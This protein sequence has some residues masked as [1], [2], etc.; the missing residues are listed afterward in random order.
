MNRLFAIARNAFFE[1]IRQP[2]YG[3]LIF[4]TFLVLVLDVPLS[5]WTMGAG[6]AEYKKTDQQ[7]L[8]NLGLSTLLVSGLLVS[9]FSAAGVL[10][11]EIEDRT[12]LTVVSKP[13]PRAVLVL[14]KYVGV[15]AALA[16]AYYLCSL[17]F[18]MTVRHGVM[19]T[20]SDKL[21]LPVIV[22]GSSALVAAILAGLFCNYFFSWNFASASVAAGAILLGAAMAVIAVV[23]KGWQIVSFGQDIS[24]ELLKAMLVGLFCVLVFAAVAIAAST[25]LGWF[26][27]L[28]VC[29][30]FFLAGS[31][32]QFLFQ[33]WAAQ[34]PLARAAYRVWPNFSFFYT[35][36]ALMQERPIPLTYVGLTGG[37]ALC[38]ILAILALGM[39]LF[40][41]R[42]LESV[43]GGAPLGVS[44]LAGL[45]RA[46]GLVC[47]FAGLVVFSGFQGL[48][49]VAYGLGL[50]GLGVVWWYFWG[51]FG[52]G[53]KWTYYLALVVTAAAVLGG[54]AAVVRSL[55]RPDARPPLSL[56]GIA[57]T[58]GAA[59]LLI[60]LLPV[61]R[62]HFSILPRSQRVHGATAS[63]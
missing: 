62:H 4:L 37:Y 56:A 55:L 22:L 5:G 17:A 46:A 31:M 50:V 48:A 61:T 11:R 12:V 51:W 15:A 21:D 42:E 34:S 45:G 30:G 3:V 16:V 38:Q 52:R 20:V 57:L 29:F 41:R 19:P 14:G 53:L 18:L 27:T 10:S 44:I 2:I 9:A 60:L 24:L 49:S 13:V 63:R 23:G 39:A 58:A 36:D 59:C 47:A 54:V 8:V 1:T 7:M 28:L 25:R 43:T 32:S 6:Q 26:L 40:Q 35:M 33:R